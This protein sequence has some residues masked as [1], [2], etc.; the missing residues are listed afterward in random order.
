MRVIPIL[1]L[2]LAAACAG[3]QET[4]DPFPLDVTHHV[5]PSQL[6]VAPQDPN[7][8]TSEQDDFACP[9]GF[10]KGARIDEY[11]DGSASLFCN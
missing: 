2:F 5:F 8:P 6:S 7:I 10:A 3:R 1:S 9:G 4:L 11:R